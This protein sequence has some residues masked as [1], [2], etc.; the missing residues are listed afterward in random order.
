MDIVIGQWDCVN[1]KTCHKE[2]KP[3]QV[4]Y[5]DDQFVLLSNY[6]DQ[7]LIKKTSDTSLNDC[8]CYTCANL[9]I[10]KQNKFAPEPQYTFEQNGLTCWDVDLLKDYK[11][12]CGSCIGCQTEQTIPSQL[13][14]IKIKD[15]MILWTE[16][17]CSLA[18]HDFDLPKVYTL[19]NSSKFYQDSDKSLVL[20][21]DCF[22]KEDWQNLLI[23]LIANFVI[24]LIVEQ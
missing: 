10:V 17:L 12:E 3:L 13:S 2:E 14:N 7:F 22:R 16:N 8:Y 11:R 15:F 1:C 23:Q 21:N 19:L 20:C 18:F 9:L 4:D 24:I 5:V 6:Y